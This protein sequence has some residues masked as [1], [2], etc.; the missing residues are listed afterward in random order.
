[1]CWL[2][3]VGQHKVDTSEVRIEVVV[4]YDS[5][6]ILGL[7]RSHVPLSKFGTCSIHDDAAGLASAAHHLMLF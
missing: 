3:H 7:A 4:H 1:M 6:K 5:L 2:E